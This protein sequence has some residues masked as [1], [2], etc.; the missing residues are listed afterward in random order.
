MRRETPGRKPRAIITILDKS[1]DDMTM[2]TMTDVAAILNCAQ[3]K[4]R[5]LC[6]TGK[7]TGALH[8]GRMWRIRAGTLRQWISDEELPKSE[9]LRGIQ[10]FAKIV[11]AEK[12]ARRRA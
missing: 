10:K 7:I 2:L 8:V 4:A 11:H 3:E 9:H 1:V 5:D 6:A 12:P